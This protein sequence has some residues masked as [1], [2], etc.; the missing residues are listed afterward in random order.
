MSTNKN[1]FLKKLSPFKHIFYLKTTQN[2]L[3][4]LKNR[5][6]NLLSYNISEADL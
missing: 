2:H 3:K 5:A 4:H 6:I 1:V